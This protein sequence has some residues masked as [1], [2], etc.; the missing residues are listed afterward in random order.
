MGLLAAHSDQKGSFWKAATPSLGTYKVACVLYNPERSETL[1]FDGSVW[2]KIISF[3][4]SQPEKA[5]SPIHV[6]ELGMV[7]HVIALH[8]ENA[9]SLISLTEFGMLTSVSFQHPQ[10]APSPITVTESGI[11]TLVSTVHPAN[12]PSL[13]FFTDSGMLMLV[14]V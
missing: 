6:T 2:Y 8:P 11:V 7:M 3:R 12:A 4:F 13:I 10:N 1:I 5:Q 14:L 9:H